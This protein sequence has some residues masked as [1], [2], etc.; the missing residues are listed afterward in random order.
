MTEK[1]ISWEV[2][3]GIV[4]NPVNHPDLVLI[5]LVEDIV[6]VF[7]TKDS[8]NKLIYDHNLTQSHSLLKKLKHHT[9]DSTIDSGNL[10]V[11]ANLAAHGL[12]YGLLPSRVAKQYTNLQK[13]KNSPEF[14]DELFLVYRPEK[15][16]NKISKEI[17]STIRSTK[18]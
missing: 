17:I 8:A 3:F 9:F 14:K 12:G 2:D 5:K 13:L 18:Y 11:I 15:H 4:I 16:N 1:V 7:H 10:E 6:T